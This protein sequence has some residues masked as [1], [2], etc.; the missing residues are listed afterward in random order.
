MSAPPQVPRRTIGQF[1][2]HVCMYVRFRPDHD[3]ITEELTGHLED[4]KDALL[5]GDPDMPLLEAEYRAVASMGDAEELGRWLDSIHSPVLGWFQ[6][7]VLPG[8]GAGGRAGVSPA[9][10]PG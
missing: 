8:G 4:H 5:E 6:N 10:A 2:D 9:P 1:C 3:S 7:L